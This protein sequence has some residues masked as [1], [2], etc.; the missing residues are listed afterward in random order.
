MAS[1]A[2]NMQVAERLMP[3]VTRLDYRITDWGTLAVLHLPP[4]HHLSL[5][6]CVYAREN[7]IPVFGS[8]GC[9]KP[10]RRMFV[11]AAYPLSQL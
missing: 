4:P 6:I 8:H 2:A 1:A 10:T 7:D 3:R 5:C 9:P 11:F